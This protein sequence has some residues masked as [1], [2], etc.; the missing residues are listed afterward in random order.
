MKED[1]EEHKIIR[2]E[3]IRIFII[4][5]FFIIAYCVIIFKLWDEQLN[6]NKKY[7]KNINIQSIR[8][9]RQPALRGSIY[10]SDNQ[11][12][13]GNTPSYDIVLHLD[14]PWRQKHG[15]YGKTVSFVMDT[16]DTLSVTIGRDIKIS[17][18]DI[19]KR[20]NYYPGVPMLLASNLNPIE[21]G[22]V[23]E[24]ISQMPGVEI[25]VNSKRSYPYK[26][27]AAHLIGYVGKEDRTEASD[28]KD[29]MYYFSD[30]IGRRGVERAYD[31]IN[32]AEDIIG[33]RGSP[34]EKVIRV[35]NRGYV[36]ETFKQT[37]E[38][39]NGND[40]VLTIDLEAQKIAN[41]ILKD[42]VGAF[43]LMDANSGALIAIQSSPS[44]DL[45]NCV[46]YLPSH[47]YKLLKADVNRPLIDRTLFGQYPPGSIFKPLVAMA[48]LESGVNPADTVF[49]DGATEIGDTKIKCWSWRSG[50][51][52]Y[53]N[54]TDAIKQS[55]NAYF[56]ENSIK[57]GLDNLLPVIKS[58]GIGQK[59][60]FML[61]GSKGKLPLREEKREEYGK[62]NAFD[63]GLTSIGQGVTLVTPLQIA[64][65]I[66][67]IANGGTLWT[68]YV[69]KSIN[70]KQGDV[71]YTKKKKIR[72][73]LNV[74]SKNLDIVQKGM[75]EVVNGDNGSG[76]NALTPLIELSGKTGTAEINSREGKRKMTWFVAYG[77]HKEKLYSAVIM[78]K[79]GESG[80]RTCA[81]LV[82]EFFE[83]W[84][85]K[86]LIR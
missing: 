4:G 51:H 3:L 26:E 33:L 44:Y 45:S 47:T 12:I 21:L 9:I 32:E 63:T 46:P 58:A 38:K 5:I 77:K 61:G 74:K 53:V 84:L 23:A 2:K 78:I 29:Y 16:V 81:P 48:F 49:C 73:K 20:M 70:N 15:A 55:C 27:V 64:I 67:A 80:G 18:D 86:K 57:L 22:V 83:K 54:M 14:E 39:V 42:K 11:I 31:T 24:M 50:G 76:E 85:K 69:L 10:S 43:V 68:P 56:I 30:L 52:G 59:T 1:K 35:D 75:W 19:K 25:V 79:D 6:S 8:K 66:S 65:Y 7:E 13:A 72:G 71:L 40:I 82:K 37:Q 41:K 28:K 36:Y 60:G 17:R 62:W 34:G